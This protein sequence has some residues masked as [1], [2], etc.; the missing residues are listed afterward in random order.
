M[1]QVAQDAQALPALVNLV[2]G[3]EPGRVASASTKPRQDG[4]DA[5]HPA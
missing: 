3:R 4:I 1:G 2:R 5:T